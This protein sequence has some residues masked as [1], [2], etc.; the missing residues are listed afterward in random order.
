LNNAGSGGRENWPFPF[1]RFMTY[2]NLH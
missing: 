1:R 2:N